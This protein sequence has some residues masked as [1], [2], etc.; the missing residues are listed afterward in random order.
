M[1]IEFGLYG[2]YEANPKRDYM[3]YYFRNKTLGGK[4]KERTRSALI[5]STISEI[6]SNGFYKLSI[7]EIARTAGLA[8]GTFYNHFESLD[9]IVK[10]AVMAVA[11]EIVENI[12][13]SIADIDDGL[14]RFIVST[15]KMISQLVTEPSWGSIFVAAWHNIP[16]HGENVR[17]FL[18]A[19]LRKAKRQKLFDMKVTNLLENQIITIIMYCISAQLK[20]GENDK[21][22][23]ETYEALLRLLGISPEQSIEIVK[24]TLAKHR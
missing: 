3:S 1:P 20:D 16:E 19:D 7:K 11:N 9:E 14:E 2:Q 17:R 6:A 4:K 8:N 24:S 22:Q 23:E 5:D 13:I 15:D 18:Q 12:A 21:I 10:Q